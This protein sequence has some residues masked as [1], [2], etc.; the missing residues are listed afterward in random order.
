MDYFAVPPH[1]CK[2]FSSRRNREAH[3]IHTSITAVFLASYYLKQNKIFTGRQIK[4][5]Y[6][7]PLLRYI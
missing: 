4:I 7:E 6:L 5:S 2:V 3:G 1:L